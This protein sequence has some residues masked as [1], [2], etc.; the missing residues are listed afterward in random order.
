[1]DEIEPI[2]RLFSVETFSHYCPNLDS[3][4][5]RYLRKKAQYVGSIFSNKTNLLTIILINLVPLSY[6]YGKSCGLENVGVW[7]VFK[8]EFYIILPFTILS[9]LMQ[10][11]GGVLKK[12]VSY[13][14]VTMG[15]LL[16]IYFFAKI[17]N[18][19]LTSKSNDN[20][21]I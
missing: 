8:S 4:L 6:L 5:T 21:S 17:I 2:R 3:R 1:M 13:A 18:N 14:I 16:G 19:Y 9:M 20:V 12:V 11:I 15:V 7:S 10:K